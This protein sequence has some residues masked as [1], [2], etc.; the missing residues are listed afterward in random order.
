MAQIEYFFATSS[1]FSYFAGT[2][3][4][5]VATRHGASITYRPM[6]LMAV[7]ARTGGLPPKELCESGLN[8][9]QTTSAA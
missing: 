3:M 7:F 4:E 6:D 9:S 5:E 8:S 2:R 1:P